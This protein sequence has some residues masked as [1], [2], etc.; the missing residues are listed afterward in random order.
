MLHALAS[1]NGQVLQS[2]MMLELLEASMTEQPLRYYYYHISTTNTYY[3][4]VIHD[5]RTP[6]SIHD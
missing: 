6:R 2:Y 4:A 1:E 3:I 5:A